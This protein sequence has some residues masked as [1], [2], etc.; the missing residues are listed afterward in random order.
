MRIHPKLSEKTGVQSPFSA[1]AADRIGGRTLAVTSEVRNTRAMESLLDGCYEQIRAGSFNVGFE[2]LIAGL[3]GIRSATARAE[4][5]E[6]IQRVCRIHPICA[7]MQ[8]DPFTRRSV[9]KPRGYAGDAVM[10]DMIYRRDSDE[11]N[12]N[13]LGQ[14]IFRYTTGSGQEA[15]A[16]RYRRSL[17][18]KMIDELAEQTDRP[19]ILSIASGHLREAE[20]SNALRE[21]AL[22]EWLALDQDPESLRECARSYRDEPV[23]V[24][25]A[26]VR[27]ILAGKLDIGQFD[28]IYSAGLF[29]YLSKPVAEKLIG[30]MFNLLK[31]NGMLLIANF[32][33]GLENAA[34][35]EAFM[36]WN[37]IY[38]TEEDMTDLLG[39]L[40]SSSAD[41]HKTFIDP[42][43]AVVYAT[44]VR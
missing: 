20:L 13:E 29:D 21:G 9:T 39:T 41:S 17:I 8:L 32:L 11:L 14:F 27:H 16:V 19:R 37:L 12:E 34:Y 36:D 33:D 2:A 3:T 43:Q 6:L 30:R 28:L 23:R 1:T 18:A 10:M 22:D 35:M 5:K 7:A 38:R 40:N 31:P 4:W 44:A 15:R 26:S 25:N 42:M 24:M